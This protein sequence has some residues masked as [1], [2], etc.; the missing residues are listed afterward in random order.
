MPFLGRAA[1]F[2]LFYWFLESV[3]DVFLFNKGSLL[4]RLFYPD[5]LSICMRMLVICV[6]ILFG[7]YTQSVRDKK[8]PADGDRVRPLT[9]ARILAAGALF[10]AGY[11]FLESFRDAF[12]NGKTSLIDALFRPDPIDFWMR[13]LPVCFL[14]LLSLY[15]Q[16][17]FNENRKI[18]DALKQANQKFAELD[19]LKNEFLSTVSHELRT[20]IAVM[21]EGVTLCMDKRVGSLNAVQQKLLH[22]TLAGIERLNRL[23]NDLLD[24]SKIEAGKM[25]LR[26]SVF[27]FNESARSAV[28]A[29]RSR[30]EKQGTALVLNVPE[31]PEWLFAD[32][33]KVRQILDNL[34]NNALQYTPQG[35]SVRLDV[36]KGPG[37]LR[38]RIT[39]TGIGIGTED[40]KKLFSKFEQFGR[41]DGPGY[42]GTGLGLSICKGLVEKHGGRIWVD[43]EAGKGSAFLFTL[44]KEPFP[45]VLVVDDE[46]EIVQIVK[47]QLRPDGYGFL[48]ANDGDTALSTATSQCPS[49]ILLDMNLGTV[50]GY[51]VVGRL[52]GDRRTAHI[53]I[54]I[55]SG[56]DVDEA[57][58]VHQEIPVLR[59]PVPSDLLRSTV[60]QVLA[61]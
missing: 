17:M 13:S 27:D 34:L 8:T 15:M 52:K 31:K 3:R 47:E 32:R 4:A 41:V 33:D 29:Q 57:R 59:K 19:L 56:Y 26:K 18:Q 16:N 61:N 45:N 2:G 54:L 24:L 42:K 11:W 30:A 48:E 20:P 6:L 49:L 38:C 1:V 40:V 12:L 53:P 9:K 35:G 51:E 23:V 46:K 22:D 7:V 60:Q 55:M 58:L 39:D 37:E 21:M 44:K 25:K 28:Q 43:S 5:A 36:E 14:F 50:S 10:S